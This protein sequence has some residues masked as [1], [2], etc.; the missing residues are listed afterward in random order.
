M[1]SCAYCEKPLICDACN[2]EVV[3]A[4]ADQYQALNALDKPV[5]CPHCEALLVCH[6]CKTPYDGN[7]ESE[8]STDL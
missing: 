2:A 1:I 4:D 7:Q 6:W 5:A 8:V 3:P